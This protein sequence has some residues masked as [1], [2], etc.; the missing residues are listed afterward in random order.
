MDIGNKIPNLTSPSE[1]LLLEFS[2]IRET[3]ILYFFAFLTVYLTAV[4]GNLLIILTVA[5]D[6][7][8]RTPMYFFLMSLAVLDLGSVS[9]MVPKAMANSLMNS[10]S[11]SYSGCVAQVF[12]LFLFLESDVFILTIM[13]HDRYVAICN[14]LQYETIMHR[15]ACIQMVVSAWIAGILNGVLHTGGTFSITFCSNMID[16]FFCEV[17]Q[18]LKLSCSDRY[19]VEV[20]LILFSLFLGIGYFIFII[21]T[22]V[23]IFSVVLKIP[24]V[25]GQKKAISTCLPH[26]TVVSLFMFTAIFSYGRPHSYTSS[27][28]NVLSAIMYAVLP[29]L[30]NPF[31][32]SMRNKEIKIALLKLSY[33]RRFSKAVA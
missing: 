22:Y 21:V 8:L 12:F 31:I 6:R 27:D 3:Q 1:F 28:L 33:C 17:P 19:L 30:L 18:I 29:P 7:H 5:L 10:R 11:I 9:V 24:S 32:Y 20:G 13:A 2:D 26:L 16:Q 4:T 14:P 23:Q 15:G 25:H